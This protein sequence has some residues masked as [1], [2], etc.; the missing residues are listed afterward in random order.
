MTTFTKKQ[1]RALSR[2][3]N[4]GEA[5]QAKSLTDESRERWFERTE[6]AVEY[7]WLTF[8]WSWSD[9]DI[10]QWF[11]DCMRLRVTSSYDCSGQWF[12]TYIRWRRNQNGAVSYQHYMQQ[13]I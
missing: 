2:V 12:T 7:G 1:K 9:D 11:E 5:R 10:E 8:D 13:D 6:T 3:F 4:Q